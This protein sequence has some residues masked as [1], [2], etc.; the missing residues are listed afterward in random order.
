MAMEN[1]ECG[2]TEEGKLKLILRYA[3]PR[4]PLLNTNIQVGCP[5]PY[6][7]LYKRLE[8]RI[9]A[10]EAFFSLEFFPPRTANGVANF[11][12]RYPVVFSSLQIRLI[13]KQ[14]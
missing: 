1:L 14:T 3:D 10:Q 6:L 8:L 7:P 4:L 2:L 11:Y 13:R 9:E 5:H 12:D